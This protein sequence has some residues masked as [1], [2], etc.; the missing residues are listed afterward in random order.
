MLARLKG[1]MPI[2]AP[3]VKPVPN[4][5]IRVPAS[6]SSVAMAEA[7]AIGWRDLGISTAGPNLMRLVFLTMRAR[8][9][10]R[11]LGTPDR[12]KAE[13]FGKNRILGS[14]RDRAGESR[15]S[16]WAFQKQASLTLNDIRPNRG[17][18]RT[19]LSV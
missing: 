19:R 12:A 6:C 7:C 17:D 10:T 15:K 1:F 5:T 3:P 16:A 18:F 13:L 2:P 9:T 8:V 4:P 14:S 11:N